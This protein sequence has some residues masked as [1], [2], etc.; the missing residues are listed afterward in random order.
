M[1]VKMKFLSITGPKADIDRVADEYLTRYEIHLENALSELKTV[2]NLRPFVETNP[3]K[4]ILAKANEFLGLVDVSD[5][6]TEEAIDLSEAI[7]VVESLNENINDI[8]NSRMLLEDEREKLNEALRV[9]EPFQELQF[10]IEEILHFGHLKYRFGRIPIEYYEKFLKYVYADLDTVFV[11]CQS[12]AEYVWGVYFVPTIDHH[13]TDAVYASLH[14][15]RIYLPDEYK[16]TPEEACIDLQNEIQRISAKIGA[17]TNQIAAKLEDN[18]VKLVRAQKEIESMSKIF[19]VRKLAACTS[20]K[21]DV[22]YIICGW[23]AEPDAYA[24][25]KEMENDPSLYCVIEE[26]D[27][28]DSELDT[29]RSRPPTKLKNLK[30]FKPFEMFVKMYGLPNYHEIDPT[31]FVA[32]TYAFIFGAMFGDIG[33]GLLLVI[34]GY[35]LYY[36]KKMDLAAIVGT[37]GIFSTIFGFL[38]GS[39]FGFEDVIEPLW[40]KPMGHMT[41]LPFIGTINTVFVVAV[42]FGMFLILMTMCFHIINGIRAKDTK[43]TWFDTNGVAGLV[44][45]ASIVA[46]IFLAMTGNKTPAFII[47]VI[48][49]GIPLLLIAFKEPITNLVQKKKEAMQESRGMF[50]AQAFFELFEVLLSYFS[51]TI[52][53]LRIGA[54]A[55]SHAAMMEVV[56]MLAGAENGG[57]PNWLVIVIG[58][59][60]VC[61]MEGLIVGIQV[62]RLEY[63]EMFSR[64]YKGTGRPFDPFLTVE[65]KKSRKR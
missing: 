49:F 41:N 51:N 31:M 26:D 10:N 1:I 27:E 8:R 53:F 60:F 20:Q 28:Q 25:Q 33:Q 59:L 29:I 56:L 39:F 18:R 55:V 13:K 14:F 63:Y 23:M 4:D 19:D 42:V 3:Y 52:S 44:F 34:G 50:L 43:D 22:F 21:Q 12:D 16:G 5:V 54:F 30:L 57:S 38:Y 58:N 36:V 40:I 24:L 32:L 46:V 9:I 64:F 47:L 17:H 15:E 7:A 62:L 37:A 6:Q 11:K 45:Y 48:M 35:T 65:N 2:H 61:G